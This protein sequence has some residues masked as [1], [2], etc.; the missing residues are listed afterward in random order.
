MIL[1]K[2][3]LQHGKAAFFQLELRKL[4]SGGVE[5]DAEKGVVYY[6]QPGSNQWKPLL[7]MASRDSV[8]GKIYLIIL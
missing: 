1:K 4:E 2:L 7:S 3:V 8:S 6:Q 5:G